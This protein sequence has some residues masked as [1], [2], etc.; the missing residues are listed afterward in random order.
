MKRFNINLIDM[1]EECNYELN[2]LRYILIVHMIENG[3]PI[4]IDL[5]QHPSEIVPKLKYG[6]IT[7]NTDDNINLE[8]VHHG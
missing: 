6:K 3:F 4:E 1:I 2:A 7:L 5:T 8:Y